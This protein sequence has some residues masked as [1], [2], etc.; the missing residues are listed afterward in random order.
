MTALQK[1]PPQL[2]E[3]ARSLEDQGL[4]DVAWPASQVDAVV[5][6]LEDAG[7]AILGGD[8]YEE[9][10]DRMRATYDNWHCDRAPG[11]SFADYVRRTWEYAWQ[12]T[13]TYVHTP[14]KSLYFVLVLSDEPTAGL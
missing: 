7:V 13:Q 9:Q 2:R 6:S 5:R 1:I 14:G 8:V 11:E 3:Y 10:G 12:Y 4:A